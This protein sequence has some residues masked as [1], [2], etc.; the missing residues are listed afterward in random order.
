MIQKVAEYFQHGIIII[1]IIVGYSNKNNI[2]TK[3][4]RYWFLFTASHPGYQHHRH[5]YLLVEI[6]RKISDTIPFFFVEVL[7]CALPLTPLVQI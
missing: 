2:L 1:M 6:V 3:T 7:K 5:F 4:H